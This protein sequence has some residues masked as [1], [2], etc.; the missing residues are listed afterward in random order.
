MSNENSLLG[1]PFFT[2]VVS[3]GNKQKFIFYCVLLL[4]TLVFGYLLMVE[5]LQKELGNLQHTESRLKGEFEDKFD[6]TVNLPMYKQQLVNYQKDLATML[7][8]LPSSNQSGAFLEDLTAIGE[9]LDITIQNIQWLPEKQE[10]IYTEFPLNLEVIGDYH[11]LALFTFQLAKLPRIVTLHNFS[12]TA[13]GHSKLR[14]II[15]IKM[16]KINEQYL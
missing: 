11:S 14:L 15:S 16:Y 9:V 5:E 12:I 4:L 3:F 7:K 13:L 6:L 1:H 10:E 2:L 8:M